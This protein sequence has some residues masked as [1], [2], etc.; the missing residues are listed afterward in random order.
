MV[1]FSPFGPEDQKKTE[2]KLEKNKFKLLLIFFYILLKDNDLSVYLIKKTFATSTI[3]EGLLNNA[4]AKRF[5]KPRF[6]GFILLN[7]LAI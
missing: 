6:S 2:L 3:S 1:K 4:V 7:D 5:P